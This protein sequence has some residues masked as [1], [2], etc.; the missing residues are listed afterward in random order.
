M[1]RL[2]FGCPVCGV[3]RCDEC[4]WKRSPAA[5]LHKGHACSQCGST[6]GTLIPR[7]H[8]AGREH[9]TSDIV[10]E[11]AR[12]EVELIPLED[13]RGHTV[14]LELRRYS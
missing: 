12:R 4:G 11:F 6:K 5:L 2:R 14:P 3:W 1:K 13:L 9:F 10:E 7:S 8:Y